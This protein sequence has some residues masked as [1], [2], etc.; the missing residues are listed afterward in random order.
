MVPVR[1]APFS[2]DQANADICKDFLRAILRD[3]GDNVGSI[4]NILNAIDNSGRLPAIDVFPS[5]SDLLDASWP[6]I[7][8]LSLFASKQNI[9]MF[10]QAMESIWLVY[11]LHSLRF[12]ALG[13]HLWFHNLMSREAGAELHYAPEDLRLGRDI[14]AELGPVDLVIH[15][16]YSKWMQ[17]R[18]YPG[19][20]HGM[21]YD[22]VVNISSLCL[23]ITSTLQYR[24]ME[25]GQEREEFFLELRE[26]GRAAD[27]R[28]AFMLAAIHWETSSDL[29][30]KVDTLNVAFN[31][32][33]PLAGA[34][35]QGLY[36][37]SLFGHNLVRLGRFEALPLPVRLAIRPPTDIWP[38]LQKMCVWCGAE[39]TKS[40]G[41]CRRIR[42]CG[43]VCQIR[44][45][46][47]SHKP[48]CSTYKFLP[49]SLPASESIA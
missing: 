41:E 21:D 3:K 32:T 22:W 10:A 13:R 47:E 20:G 45:W 46:R 31:V 12:Q 27:K 40:C 8:G 14:A 24:Q 4:I 16:F 35:V 34:F 44:H 28:L 23:R 42:Y 43:R 1:L 49:D 30:D 33:P 5:R 37:D 17:E 18:G 2:W 29:Q 11:F 39:S 15:R 7:F 25:S 38:E 48:A 6:G 9:A 26:H 19:M 36:I